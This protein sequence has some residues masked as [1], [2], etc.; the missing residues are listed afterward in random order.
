MPRHEGPCH[1]CVPGCGRDEH[2]GEL[3]RRHPDLASGR[4]EGDAADDVTGEGGSGDIDGMEKDA[5]RVFIG[6]DARMM[7][8]LYRINPKGAAGFIARQMKDLLR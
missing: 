4:R 6:R 7:D 1:G 2:H 5:Y 8:T 3:G